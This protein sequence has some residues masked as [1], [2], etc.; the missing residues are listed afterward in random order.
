M[1]TSADPGSPRRPRSGGLRPLN[2]ARLVERITRAA[3]ELF[4]NVG[5]A[6]VTMEQIAASAEVS[7]RTLYKHFPAKEAILAHLLENEVAQDV[8]R[9]RFSFDESASFRANASALL[10]ESAAWC[11]RHPDHL[12]PYI[13]YKIATFEPVV[14]PAEERGLVKAWT[15][16][17]AAGQ[18]RGDLD[19]TRPAAQLAIY[20][21]YLYFGALMRWIT[22]RV[23]TLTQ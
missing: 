12:L 14:D 2:K 9:L 8:A 18:L 4:G 23:P 10:A 17:I 19:T 20:F 15:M 7:K 11:E 6:P 13:R 1:T 5:Y 22:H 3:A 21:H 16:L